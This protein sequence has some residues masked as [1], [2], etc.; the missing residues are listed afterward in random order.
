MPIE[1]VCNPNV[2]TIRADDRVG[3]AAAQL[4]AAHVGDLIARR[5]PLIPSETSHARHRC[6][7]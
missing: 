2:A 3:D 1:S 4:R 7:G 6:D 5:A